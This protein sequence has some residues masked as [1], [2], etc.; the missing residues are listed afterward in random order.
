[1]LSLDKSNR[2][3]S[4]SFCIRLEKGLWLIQTVRLGCCLSSE[5]SISS[6]SG[7]S[8]SVFL[9]GWECRYQL[10]FVMNF[11][12]QHSPRNGEIVLWRE[13]WWRNFESNRRNWSDLSLKRNS[14]AALKALKLLL[15]V[16][17][18]TAF[19]INQKEVEEYWNCQGK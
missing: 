9:C 14:W 5:A 16:T 18:W 13:D 2:Y 8:L 15:L 3:T 19:L 11:L 7:T 12:L 6:L 1:M 10:V 4:S 17:I